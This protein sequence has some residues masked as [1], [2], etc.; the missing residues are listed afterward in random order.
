MTS[1]NGNIF[2]VIG[3]LCGK[4]T[5]DPHKGQWRGALMFSLICAWISGWVNNGEASDLKRHRTHY[6]VIVMTLHFGLILIL[7]SI[8]LA[9]IT[10]SSPLC[11]ALNYTVCI[12]AFITA[13]YDKQYLV[14]W[15]R[16]KSKHIFGYSGVENR[17]M[18]SGNKHIPSNRLY[19]RSQIS[20]NRQKH[21]WNNSTVWPY[22][23]CGYWFGCY[24]RCTELSK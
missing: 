24:T 3:H 11:L 19:R 22:R 16:R 4:F 20:M 7:W 2:R 23:P 15:F 17:W 18:N 21:P 8:P 9:W 12:H 13:P 1:S 6:D 5:G 10:L 14:I